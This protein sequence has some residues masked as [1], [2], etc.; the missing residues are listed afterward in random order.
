MSIHRAVVVTSGHSVRRTVADHAHLTGRTSAVVEADRRYFLTTLSQLRRIPDD[1]DDRLR[2]LARLRGRFVDA[3]EAADLTSLGAHAPLV[4]LEGGSVTGVARY[5]APRA[6]HVA[7][8]RGRRP[9]RGRPTAGGAAPGRTVAGSPPETAEFRA[10]AAIDS[11][12]AVRSGEAFSLGVGF[13]LEGDDADLVVDPDA[14]P[15]VV[16]EVQAAGVG[17]SFPDGVRRTLKV[18]RADPTRASTTFTVQADEVGQDTDATLLVTFARKGIACG[19][20]LRV[21]RVH[22]GD[23][24][25]TEVETESRPATGAAVTEAAQATGADLTVH[26]LLGDGKLQWRFSSSHRGVELPDHD[27]VVPLEQG[28]ARNFAQNMLDRLGNGQSNAEM[29]HRVHAMSEMITRLVP[30][31]FWAAVEAVWAKVRRRPPTLL[32]LTDEPQLPWELVWVSADNVRAEL[33][34]AELSEAPI[35]ML[36]QVGRWLNTV[37]RPRYGPPRPAWPPEMTLPIT[38]MVVVTGG[39]PA[40]ARGGLPDATRE[41][42]DIAAAYQAVELSDEAGLITVLDNEVTDRSGQPV[43]PSVVHIAMHGRADDRS[44]PLDAQLSPQSG[45]GVD[46]LDVSERK[47]SEEAQPL[48]FLNACQVG[49]AGRELSQ[50]TGIPAELITGGCRACIAPLWTVDDA[51]ARRFAVEFYRRTI[52]RR[53]PVGRA[54]AELRREF[55]AD[56]AAGTLTPLAYVYYG[57]PSLRLTR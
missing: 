44:R 10:Y 7:P 8:T 4:V 16:F 32:L 50:Y 39:Y 56:Q 49:A 47:L 37:N 2:L 22:A 9:A 6:G 11:P 13:T 45:P 41:S 27:V 54:L 30:P 21:I 19:R 42:S 40:D 55:H 23:G 33:L 34:P 24:P 57:H 31:E 14:P 38:G 17:F 53:Q 43:R 35:A 46:V 1:D 36:W 3:I 12:G 28:S 51:L 29:W 5:R 48:V 25:I 26:I 52:T 15:T 20:A 18:P